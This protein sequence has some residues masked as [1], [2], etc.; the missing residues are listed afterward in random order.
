MEKTGDGKSDMWD[1]DFGVL[2][3]KQPLDLTKPEV[4]AA[5]L[6]DPDLEFQ[7]GI[8]DFKVSRLYF[9]RTFCWGPAL[10]ASQKFLSK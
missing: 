2:V 10:S 8:S 3:L 1:Y 9:E 4:K 7:L 6:P 5:C